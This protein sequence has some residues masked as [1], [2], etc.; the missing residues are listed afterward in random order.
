MAMDPELEDKIADVIEAE[1]EMGASEEAT[2]LEEMVEEQE[3]ANP[4]TE[5]PAAAVESDE[6]AADE[7]AAAG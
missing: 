3:A 2:A 7:P 6:P 1:R 5:A 4:V